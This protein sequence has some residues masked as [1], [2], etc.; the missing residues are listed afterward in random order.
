MRVMACAILADT[1]SVDEA[2]ARGKGNTKDWLL[3][4]SSLTAG[5]RF[6]GE[7]LSGRAA[8]P[9]ESGIAI[10]ARE[11][12]GLTRPKSNGT[13]EAWLVVEWTRLLKLERLSPR[14]KPG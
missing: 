3:A 7:A 11:T 13:K 4:L 5:P 9:F 12:R 10:D 2:H 6:A 1:W 14:L 8:S